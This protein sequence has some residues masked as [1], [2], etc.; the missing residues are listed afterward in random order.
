MARYLL[1][2]YL[3]KYLSPQKKKKREKRRKGK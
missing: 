2:G 3:T 1:F